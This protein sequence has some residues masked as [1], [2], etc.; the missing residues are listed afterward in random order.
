[1]I[2]TIKCKFCG[3][4]IEVTE[5]LRHQI[6]EAVVSDLSTKHKEELEKVKKEAEDFALKRAT[7]EIDLRLK[8]K[9]NETQELQR[10]NKDLR[11]QLLNMAK[12]IR[13][14]KEQSERAELENQKRL[15]IELEKAKGELAKTLSEKSQFEI[16]E[17]KKQ[18]DDTKK[19]LDD[20][21]SKLQQKSQQ[22][23]GE[24][25]E[26]DLESRLQSNFPHDEV[27][28][29]GKGA[30]GG[31][32]IQKVRNSCGKTAGIILWETKRAKWTPSWL[33]KLRDDSRRVE[34]SVSVLVCEL[35]PKEV[36]TF[37]II[38][39]VVVTSYQYAIPLA[40][41]LRRG[42][43]QVAVAKSGATNKDEKLEKLYEYLQSV[44]F[45]H[46]FEAY[47]EGVVEM[48]N[49]LETEKRSTL[50]IWKKKGDSNLA[51]LRKYL[52]YV[53]RTPRYNGF[54]FT[55]HKTPFSS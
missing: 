35:P 48:Q 14:L 17:L 54:L 40:G 31:D 21:K 25:L 43:I 29:V 4:D 37:K 33:P 36:E 11:E 22:L 46:R 45:R 42:I 52:K 9:E 34:A 16:L 24:V 1:M 13:A 49:D 50:R 30:Q 20:A 47:V 15:S 51:Y 39:G 2:N 7:E 5:A 55:R 38:D 32:I 41:I 53:R 26:L 19:S 18:L 3:K 10:V 8:D 23:Q 44:T 6:E 27:T 12:A 28:P